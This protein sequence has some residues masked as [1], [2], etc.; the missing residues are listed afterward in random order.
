[1]FILRA[2]KTKNEKSTNKTSKVNQEGTAASKTVESEEDKVKVKVKKMM[3]N[4]PIET[5]VDCLE[6][7]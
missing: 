4:H 2:K 5:G 6:V 7:V 1:L 3:T